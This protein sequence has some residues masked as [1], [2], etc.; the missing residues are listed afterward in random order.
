MEA[1][2]VVFQG[3]FGKGVLSRARPQHSISDQ[4]ERE[5]TPAH[6]ITGLLQSGRL[7]AVSWSLFLL[8]DMKACSC[9]SSLSPGE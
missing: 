6:V 3:Y 9:L 8:Q 1:S 2:P 4:W 5:F 7:P